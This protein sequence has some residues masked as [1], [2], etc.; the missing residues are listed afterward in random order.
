[1]AEIK[2]YHGTSFESFQNILKD[3]F[4]GYCNN[5]WICSDS[6]VS[7]FYNPLQMLNREFDTLEECENFAIESAF[8]NGRIAAARQKS[9]ANKIM[10]IELTIDD[11]FV[12]L[13]DSCPNME[14]ACYVRNDDIKNHGKISSVFESEFLA[15][16]SLI[17]LVGCTDNEYYDASDLSPLEISVIKQLE[18]MYIDELD[19]IEYY[20]VS[21]EYI[22]L[23]EEA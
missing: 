13:D 6:D 12:K 14:Y 19:Y 3:G 16:M 21:S 15:N 17:Y 2:I 22:I 20:N 18:G 1:M 8:S 10:V 23:P 11:S 4:D 9:S 7:Y 5:N